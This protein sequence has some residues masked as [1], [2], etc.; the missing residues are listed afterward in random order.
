MGI[1]LSFIQ[2]VLRYTDAKDS[3]TFFK[4]VELPCQR[5]RGGG[6]ICGEE[7]IELDGGFETNEVESNEPSN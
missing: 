3:E 4:N 5:T 7:H 2:L 6:I 1:A